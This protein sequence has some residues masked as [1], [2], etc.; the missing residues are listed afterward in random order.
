[1]FFGITDNSIRAILETLAAFKTRWGPA[2]LRAGESQAVLIAEEL[3][4]N[5]KIEFER[6]TDKHGV[7]HNKTGWT[8]GTFHVEP[9]PLGAFVVGEGAA[10][11]VEFGSRAHEIVPKSADG[12]LMF[13]TADGNFVKTKH[14]NHP[15]VAPDPY[16]ERAIERT[17][18]G[19]FAARIVGEAYAAVFLSSL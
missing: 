7:S 10:S 12:W 14:V 11:L 8:L 9:H 4:K 13:E 19:V 15:G 5:I 6:G 18:M 16:V 17:D 3:N 1:M 2:L